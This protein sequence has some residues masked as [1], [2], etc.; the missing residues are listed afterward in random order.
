MASQGCGVWV[1]FVLYYLDLLLT[2]LSAVI[3]ERAMTFSIVETIEDVTAMDI[4]SIKGT[5]MDISYILV[6]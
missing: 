3:A 4:S 1:K 6:H 5:V 2:C